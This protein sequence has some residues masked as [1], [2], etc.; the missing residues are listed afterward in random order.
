[1]STKLTLPSLVLSV[2]EYL[3]SYSARGHAIIALNLH[4]L[5]HISASE[6]VSSFF[7][8]LPVQLTKKLSA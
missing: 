8:Y 3:Q 2:R 4:I 7:K 1:M 5:Y 6:A